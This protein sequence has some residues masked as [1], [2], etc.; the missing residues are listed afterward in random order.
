MIQELNKLS[1]SDNFR[2]FGI[3]MTQQKVNGCHNRAPYKQTL[4]VQ[5]GWVDG[6]R[7]MVT[8]PFAMSNDCQYRHTELGKADVACNGCRWKQ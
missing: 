2:N 6:K 7:N 4:Q 1:F 8:I 3:N 5:D